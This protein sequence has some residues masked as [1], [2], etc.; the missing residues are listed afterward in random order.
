MKY[1]ITESQYSKTKQT[2]LNSFEKV[3]IIKTIQ[4]FKLSP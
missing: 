3:G 2:I 1:I 4:K